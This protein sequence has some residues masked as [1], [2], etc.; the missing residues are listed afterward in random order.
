MR[1]FFKKSYTIL[2]VTLFFLISC[3]DFVEI[4]PPTNEVVQ[5][6]V[7]T[8]DETA[9]AAMNGIY[10]LMN[11]TGSQFSSGIEIF[12]GLASDELVNF[13]NNNDYQDISTNEIL[14][15]NTIIFSNF[16]SNGYQIV[17]N[18]NAVI[19]GLDGNTDLTPE[20]RNQL[21]AEALFIRGYAHFYLVNL[22]G[23]VPYVTTT[24]VEINNNSSRLPEVEVYDMIINDLQEAE[25][26]AEA[27]LI[28][29]ED[30]DVT[31]RPTFWAITA[32]L[33]RTYLYRND[34]AL[35][36]ETA[37]IIIDEG[38]FQL[39]SD[40]N[41]VF[42]ATSSE[43]IWQLVPNDGF[44]TRLGELLP[45]TF[46]GPGNFSAF[47]ATAFQPGFLE[48]FTEGDGRIG[49]WIGSQNENSFPTKYKNSIS[50]SIGETEFPEYTVMLR[51]A[52]QYLIRAEARL[53]QGNILA[54]LDDLDIVRN[55]AGLPNVSSS[56][57]AEILE[58][59][60]EERQRELFAEGGHR[61]LDLKR[62]EM[63]DE[64]IGSLKPLWDAT[65]I[66]WPIPEQEI[67][68][69]SNLLPQNDGY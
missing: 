26:F 42:R 12:T 30:E 37:A 39:E 1:S 34:W 7:F 38:P 15:D 65:D 24:D 53:Q 63:A 41:E 21:L 18:A 66:L 17:N 3:E 69:N 8:V 2:I 52:E 58:L 31:V 22:F 6:T 23:P 55:R 20:L 46:L 49:A 33:A 13:F 35:A 51:L 10:V 62:T 50:L 56:N 11:S 25:T 28:N 9:I 64:V 14:S 43:A 67:F 29:E 57:P 32:L 47:G 45:I 27:A 16:W 60:M 40:L 19:E 4:D 48:V 54:A 44:T 5:E 36:E 61:W 68:N 59:I